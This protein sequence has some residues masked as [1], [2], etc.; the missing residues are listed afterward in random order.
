MSSEHDIYLSPLNYDPVTSG[1]AFIRIIYAPREARGRQGFISSSLQRKS[2]LCIPFLR[3][4]LSQSQFPHSCVCER[5]LYPQDWS[6]YFLQQNRQ[7]D[8]GNIKMAHRHM[9]VVIGT[10]AA[11]FLFW[12]HLF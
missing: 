7:I 11:Q 5:F 1:L 8:C 10:V 9:N 4:A 12:E 6:T 3:I 2:Y